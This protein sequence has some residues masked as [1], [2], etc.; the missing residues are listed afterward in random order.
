[1]SLVALSLLGFFVVAAVIYWVMLF[2][3]LV[4]LRNEVDRAWANIDVILKQRFDE[5]PKLIST[6]ESHMGYEQATLQKII[7]ARNSYL[8]AT[9]V[10]AKAESEAQ[11][12]AGLKS[13][14]ALSENYPQLRASDSFMQFQNRISQLEEALSDRR[15]F[16]N[17]SVT[18]LNTRIAQIPEV[19]VA[20]AAGCTKQELFRVSAQE[21]A[22]VSVK[23]NVPGA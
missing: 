15:E 14:F 8:G 3:G 23:M 9:S 17:S 18:V 12:S 19:F 11:L 16:Y 13:L 7:A 20:G 5:I 6:V 21:R 4:A 1:M 2:N 22:D 10:G